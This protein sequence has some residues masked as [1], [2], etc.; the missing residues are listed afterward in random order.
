[1][2]WNRFAAVTC[3]SLASAGRC[4]AGW[5]DTLGLVIPGQHFATE[6]GGPTAPASGPRNHVA[7]S[8]LAQRGPELAVCA[9]ADRYLWC[10]PGCA[11]AGR[12][13]IPCSPSQC[14]SGRGGG[15]YPL[16]SET[17]RL[18]GDKRIHGIIALL[19]LAAIDA[20][21][22]VIPIKPAWG[23]HPLSWQAAQTG[24]AVTAS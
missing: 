22:S 21:A 5:S 18:G 19:R 11:A 23:S 10:R 20:A 4:N 7:K 14:G 2:P 16:H 8:A 6:R 17:C 1:M 12:S 3:V 9:S 13:L 24:Q 15:C